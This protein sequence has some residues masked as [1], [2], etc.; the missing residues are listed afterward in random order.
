MLMVGQV[1]G[2]SV[3]AIGD[4][5]SS[6]ASQEFKEGRSID[7]GSVATTLA[8]GRNSI[9]ETA[10]VFSDVAT[11]ASPARA[12]MGRRQHAETVIKR[13][14]ENAE[15]EAS[16]RVQQSFQKTS[17]VLQNQSKTSPLPKGGGPAPLKGSRR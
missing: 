12:A 15:R 6:F 1:T 17:K 16:V 11:V 14:T 13:E 5:A 7:A 3:S 4:H 9:G 8:I 2:F 10:S